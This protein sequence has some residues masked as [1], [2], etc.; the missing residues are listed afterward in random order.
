MAS[1]PLTCHQPMFEQFRFGSWTI[2][3]VKGYILKSEGA[4]RD[5][6]VFNDNVSNNEA[7][8]VTNSCHD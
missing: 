5:E 3:G 2:T 8:Y 6:L 4:E 1:N 7:H